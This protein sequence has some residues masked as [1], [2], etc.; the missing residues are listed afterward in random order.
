MAPAAGRPPSLRTSLRAELHSALAPLMARMDLLERQNRLL[1]RQTLIPD[2]TTWRGS[3]HLMLDAAPATMVFDRSMLCRED[4]F[5]QPYFSYWT[6]ALGEQLRF[7]R[8]LWEFVFVCQTLYERNCLTDGSRGLGF[9][10]GVEPLSAYFAS[11]GCHI[12]G[13]DMAS[14]EA[15]TAG[16]ATTAQHAAG[17]QALARPAICPTDVFEQNVDFRTVDMNAIPDDLTGFDFCW[18]ACALEHLGSIE[19]GLAFIEQSVETLRPGGIATHTT[20]FNLSSNEQTLSEGGTVLFRRKDM[21]ELARRLAAKGH[22]MALLD[23]DPGYGPVDR[24][25]DVP[26]YLEQ[27]HLKL[28]LEGYAATSIGLVIRRGP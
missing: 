11:R 12:L 22:D 7:H 2:E 25:I 13:T 6:T 4:S 17:K 21:E 1:M 9:G 5:R 8:K 19:R 16:W 18:S 20:E 24:Y 27:P 26:P 28:A 10:V 23:F 3:P 14:D 15:V